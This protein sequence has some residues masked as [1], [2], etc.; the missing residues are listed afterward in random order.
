MVNKNELL[1][2]MMKLYHG[3]SKAHRYVF[4]FEM[5]G[6]IYVIIADE[7]LVDGCVIL[8]KASRGAGYSIRFKPNRAIKNMLINTGAQVLCS[9]D[10]FNGLVNN[11]KYNKGEIFE[12]LVT[13]LVFGQTWVKDNVPFYVDGDVTDAYGVKYQVKFEKATFTNEKALY[14][15]TNR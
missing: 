6:M 5:N 4:G 3:M 10:Y 8:D 15:L 14:N 7:Q 9:T 11:S 13:E 1:R 12:K 2:N